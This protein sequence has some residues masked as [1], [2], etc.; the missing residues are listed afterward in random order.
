[1]PHG[2]QGAPHYEPNRS[3][4]TP[5]SALRTPHSALAPLSLLDTTPDHAVDLTKALAWVQSECNASEWAA[6][7][8]ARYVA[9]EKAALGVVP[10]R[11]QIVFE[12]FF[13]ESGGMQLVIH[14]PLGNRINRAWGLALRKRFCRSF[15]FELQAAAD[16]DGVV[17]SLGPQHSFPIDALFK[18]L[19]PANGQYLLTQA[20]LAAPMFQT[21]W[22]W[23]ITRALAVLRSRNGKKVPP[24]LQ[25]MRSDDLLAAVFPQTVGCLE[26][27]S[28]D[29]EIPDHPLVAQTIDDCLHEAMDLDRWLDLL[30]EVE[31]GDV[32]FLARDTREPSPFSHKLLNSNPYTF[33]DDAPL[34]ERRA[35]AVATRRSLSI[36]SVRDLGQLD[37][38]AIKQV[39]AEAWPLVRSADELHDALLTLVVAT[40]DE[41]AAWRPWLEELIAAG[42]ATTVGVPALAGGMPLPP[43]GG[44]PIRRF[45][46]AAERWPLVRSLYT[47]AIA[48]PAVQLPPSLEVAFES[49]A[50]SVELVRGRLQCSGP[51]TAEEL[52]G[53]LG[54]PASTIFA[55][56]EA[57]EGQGVA[58]RGSFTSHATVPL[59]VPPSGGNRSSESTITSPPE[60]GTTNGVKS[61]VEWC[62]RRLLARIHRRTLDGLRRKIQPVEPVDYLRF[63]MR[64]QRVLPDFKWRGRA[65]V[66]E[67]I[68]QLQGFEIAA[69][70]WE[71]G[72]LPARVQGYDPAWLDELSYSGQL[73]WGRLRPPRKDE[74]DLPTGTALNRSMPLSLLLRENLAWLLPVDRVSAED[75]ARSNARLVLEALLQRGA[76]FPHEIAALTQ[77][78][79]AQVTEALHELAALGLATADAFATVR[80]LVASPRRGRPDRIRLRVHR[81]R[82]RRPR[83]FG[84]PAGRWSL[85][86]GLVANGSTA[87]VHSKELQLLAGAQGTE[88]P[89]YQPHDHQPRDRLSQWAWQLLNRWGVVFRDLLAREPVAPSWPQLV[90]TFRR[91]EA[92]GEIRGGRFI[93]GV[94]GEQYALSKAVEA[95]R[96]VRDEAPSGQCVVISAAD[97]LNLTGILT[98]VPRV[99]STHTN[100]LALRDG[101]FIATQQAGE[102]QFHADVASELAV[103]L[104]RKLRRTG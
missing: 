2:E 8:A 41:A 86:P 4:T 83:G 70:S 14:A 35:R 54:L 46:I 69:G 82:P 72:V 65:G 85:F 61:R 56:L 17:L 59:V 73:V 40:A 22:R 39:A 75:F 80:T 57:L 101:R 87:E 102:I 81:D 103:D 62:D 92:R 53:L 6:E 51:Q 19:S 74:G 88:V 77:L 45:V 98:D 18:M 52:A 100:S 9:A 12:R 31:R 68:T 27:H 97:P 16:D 99:P 20:L 55:A 38:E 96:Q 58:M 90:G 47:S 34:E 25:R 15:D 78:L 32:E 93:E 91:M 3:S 21:R 42:R 28:G 11:R 60:V 5:D 48:N 50:G 44:T 24:N 23:N 37:P 63:L 66:A 67:A 89:Y 64:H 1:V 49:A 79:P 43:E 10:T 13:D 71:S 36:E 26:N 30:R 7:Q 95:L 76:L 29:I 33:L 94:G 84:A 104:S